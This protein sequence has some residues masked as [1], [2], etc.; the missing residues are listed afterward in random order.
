VNAGGVTL[1]DETIN[2]A[3][4]QAIDLLEYDLCLRYI[5]VFVLCII[6]IPRNICGSE[7]GLDDQG[8]FVRGEIQI[9]W[10]LETNGR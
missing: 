1:A 2:D 10:Y 9:D 8:D 5:L 6:A 7:Y 4:N 3:A